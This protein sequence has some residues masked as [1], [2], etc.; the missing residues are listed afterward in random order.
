MTLKLL[1]HH[2]KSNKYIEFKLIKKNVL[3]IN[4]LFR[5]YLSNASRFVSH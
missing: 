2:D 3:I 4:I 5:R 1:N